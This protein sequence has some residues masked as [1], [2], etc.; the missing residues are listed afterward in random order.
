[1]TLSSTVPVAQD[2]I[3]QDSCCPRV[4]KRSQHS[5]VF[6]RIV[7]WLVRVRM[8]GI[9][10]QRNARSSSPVVRRPSLRGSLLRGR[11]QAR[12]DVET[13]QQYVLTPEIG[14][15]PTASPGTQSGG[16]TNMVANSREIA[17]SR[18]RRLHELQSHDLTN[19]PVLACR[20]DAGPIASVHLA[21]SPNC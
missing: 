13:P 7:D 5:C 19:V 3:L 20:E 15:P 14:S 17:M 18:L 6:V 11:E 4:V 12:D 2:C 16:E 8:F 21:A 10:G 1:M 9:G